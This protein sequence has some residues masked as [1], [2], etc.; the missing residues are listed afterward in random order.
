MYLY[1][2]PRD[3]MAKD[4]MLENLCSTPTWNAPKLM[5]NISKL[6]FHVF[7]SFM[8]NT[9]VITHVLE[10]LSLNTKHLIDHVL[11]V[12]CP[13]QPTYIYIYIINNW[14]MP[15]KQNKS[16]CTCAVGSSTQYKI[17]HQ[18]NHHDQQAH[19]YKW[20]VQKFGILHKILYIL[21]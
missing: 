10:S 6:Y 12:P 13:T 2:T 20:Q 17:K 21:Q 8:L 11:Q 14:L 16:S 9:N 7:Q 15:N 19:A 5:P 4:P 18:Y 1:D 3:T